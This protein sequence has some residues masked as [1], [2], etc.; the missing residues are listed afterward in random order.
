MPAASQAIDYLII[1]HL[2]ADSP[3]DPRQLGGSAAYAGLTAARLGCRV[4]VVSACGPDLDLR[5]L[6]EVE[7]ALQ[8]CAESTTFEN[9]ETPAGRR[10]RLL[11]R[12]VPLDRSHIPAAW[13]LAALVHLAPVADEVQAELAQSFPSAFLALTPQGWLRRWDQSGMVS[14]RDWMILEPLLARANAVVLSREDLAGSRQPVEA[15]A[16]RCAILAVTDGPMGCELFWEGQHVRIPAPAQT[17]IDSTGAGDIFAA[18]FFACLQ[19]GEQ[20]IKAAQLANQLAS[21]SVTRSG[22]AGVPA[23]GQLR[24]SGVLAS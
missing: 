5:P 3:D 22:I 14:L 12:A 16:Q 9:R 20:P 23:A 19:L 17:A 10:Q 8:A 21:D 11:R 4:G 18:T 2:T 1:G 24:K 15:L 7:L 13:Q 6:R